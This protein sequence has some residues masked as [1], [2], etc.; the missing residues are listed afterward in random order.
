MENVIEIKPRNKPSEQT[1]MFKNKQI[2]HSLHAKGK[3]KMNPYYREMRRT[4]IIFVPQA[5]FENGVAE[6]VGD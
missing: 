2:I 5:C 3:I 1:R 4:N 6:L